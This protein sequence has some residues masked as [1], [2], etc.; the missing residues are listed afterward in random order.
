MGVHRLL[1][2]RKRHKHKLFVI[3]W[4]AAAAQTPPPKST[5]VLSDSGG[6]RPPDPPPKSSCEVGVPIRFAIGTPISHKL[7][8][9]GAWGAAAP[10]KMTKSLCL[11]RFLFLEIN[12]P[13]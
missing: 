10:Q 1:V 13:R 7:C 6:R 8:G 4:E 3:F 12:N 2:K 5:I 9:E 11:C